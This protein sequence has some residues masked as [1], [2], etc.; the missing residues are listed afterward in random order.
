MSLVGQDGD[1]L[2]VG[3]G[4]CDAHRTNVE[5]LLSEKRNIECVCQRNRPATFALRHAVN[6]AAHRTP[7]AYCM[8][9]S[10]AHRVAPAVGST[11]L[12]HDKQARRIPMAV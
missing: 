8:A 10:N 11:S 6:P 3:W 7:R 2:L 4:A 5:R 9:I 1:V 12:A